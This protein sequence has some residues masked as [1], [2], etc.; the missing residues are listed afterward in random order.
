[1]RDI[2]NLFP[3]ISDGVFI[4]AVIGIPV[5][6]FFAGYWLISYLVAKVCGNK[7]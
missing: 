7:D 3:A 1:M 5:G 2:F 4:V 6:I